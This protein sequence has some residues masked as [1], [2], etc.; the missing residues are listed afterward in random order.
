MTGP[1]ENVIILFRGG[2]LPEWHQLDEAR[3]TD[4]ERRHVDLMLSV[5]DRHGL[6]GIHGYRLLGPRGNWERFWTIEFPDL[7][8][9]EAWMSAEAEPPY[10]RYGHY[11][12]TLA[13]RWQPEC[14]NWLPRKAESPV[15]PD[16][17]PHIIPA[18][19][20][21]PS[22][23]VLLAFGGRHRGADAYDSDEQDEERWRRMREVSRDHGL[24]HGEVFQS[25]GA[26]DRGDYAWILEFRGLAGIEAWI[27]AETAPPLAAAQRHDFHVARRWAPEYFATWAAGRGG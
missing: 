24:F 4:Y 18:L 25:L 23:I 9:A 12:Y 19:S 6:I 10:G 3:R 20:A 5:A 13:R 14:L 2:R 7:A 26:S 1:G 16:A 15:T 27:D 22:S 21:D 8:G 17:D 11:D